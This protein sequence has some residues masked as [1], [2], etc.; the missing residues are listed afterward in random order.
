MCYNNNASNKTIMSI[1][2][3]TAKDYDIDMRSAAFVFAIF[4]AIDVV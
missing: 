3:E 4:K 2:L 1:A